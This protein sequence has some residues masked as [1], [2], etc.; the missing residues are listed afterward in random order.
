MSQVQKAAWTTR[1]STPANLPV[2][3]ARSDCIAQP[4]G[5]STRASNCGSLPICA[6]RRGL[7]STSF[8]GSQFEFRRSTLSPVNTR[9]SFGG[10]RLRLWSFGGHLHVA[11]DARRLSDRGA[12]DERLPWNR[13]LI[14][15]E[16]S[17]R[18]SPGFKPPLFGWS[19]LRPATSGGAGR[20]PEGP[21]ARAAPF[22][23]SLVGNSGVRA[24]TGRTLD[25]PEERAGVSLLT[26]RRVVCLPLS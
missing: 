3:R 9:S 6:L 24:L 4:R 20:P 14:S 19:F 26:R 25:R 22:S 1:T 8:R 21:D 15:I 13:S 7:L 10:S 16:G 12:R 18:Y 5:S 17:K 11:A 2:V 23:D